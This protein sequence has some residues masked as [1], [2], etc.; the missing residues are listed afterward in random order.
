MSRYSWRFSLRD[1]NAPDGPR[2]AVPQRWCIPFVL[3]LA[4][5]ATGARPMAKAE[6]FPTVEVMSWYVP[7]ASLVPEASSA[8]SPDGWNDLDARIVGI[9]YVDSV[10][11]ELATGNTEFLDHGVGSL[12][13][14]AGDVVRGAREVKTTVGLADRSRCVGD[15][16]TFR[17]RVDGDVADEVT[18][19][20]GESAEL[21][22]DLREADQLRLETAHVS[23]PGCSYA[24]F[25][26]P[27]LY[28]EDYGPI[29]K[30]RPVGMN[31]PW[32][33]LGLSSVV[34]TVPCPTANG[35][36]E[37]GDDLVC[38]VDGPGTGSLDLLSN[39]TYRS[40]EFLASSDVP[41]GADLRVLG[42]GAELFSTSLSAT[43]TAVSVRVKDVLR[44][45]IEVTVP[46]G[47]TG[48]VTLQQP[49]LVPPMAAV[50]LINGKNVLF[51]SRSHA[52]QTFT[53]VASGAIT[54][55][56][57][58]DHLVMIDTR[59]RLWLKSD[60]LT[61]PWTY[62]ARGAVE[63][64][65]AGHTVAMID[66]SAQ[67]W[68]RDLAGADVWVRRAR[69][70]TSVDLTDDRIAVVDVSARGWISESGGPFTLVRSGDVDQ[71][72]ASGDRAALLTTTGD[73][74]TADGPAGS[75]WIQ[76]LDQ[77]TDIDI[78]GSRVSAVRRG[79]AYIA[80]GGPNALLWFVGPGVRDIE[81]RANRVLLRDS[82]LQINLQVGS[83]TNRTWELTEGAREYALT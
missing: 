1:D 3:L 20:Y 18:V 67:L 36:S 10:E 23:G 65:V 30:P 59:R 5:I 81:L 22:A 35:W 76:R 61:N 78:D 45:R 16:V 69:G 37:S 19:G 53:P 66:T 72:E 4:L 57:S 48:R 29:V 11:C 15:V 83:R 13:Y 50:A 54:F 6:A 62:L 56:L 47:G 64:R 41:A 39:R 8:C 43:P 82:T 46:S 58:D 33:S 79:Y 70:I 44:V 12:A 75:P 32:L 25:A 49:R 31:A 28:F 52:D 51:A 80:D 55:D 14:A 73:F 24:V 38:D 21:T 63:A 42:D 2:R 17:L 34:A 7:V 27:M 9:E 77:V 68:V 40:L 60:S 26:T 71:L 74:Y